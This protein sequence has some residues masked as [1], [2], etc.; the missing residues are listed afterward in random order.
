VS[1]ARTPEADYHY[2]MRIRVE[3]K[4]Q[5]A[6]SWELLGNFSASEAG[7]RELRSVL[8]WRENPLDAFSQ[9]PKG[10]LWDTLD[11][12]RVEGHDVRIQFED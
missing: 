8:S 7:L 9:L 3:M 5:G 2:A 10:L 11:I 1:L 12:C 4:P 6:A